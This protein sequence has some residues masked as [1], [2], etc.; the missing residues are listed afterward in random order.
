MP[1]SSTLSLLFGA[2][3]VVLAFVP[4]GNLGLGLG[5]GLI[6]GASLSGFGVAAQKRLARTRAAYVLPALATS[7]MLK[8]AA[9]FVATFVFLRFPQTAERFDPLTTLLA[10]AFAAMAVLLTGTVEVS[11]LLRQSG[12]DHPV[13][14]RPTVA[15]GA[16]LQG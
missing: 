4:G 6:L 15:Q 14:D 2:L 7:F 3:G 12:P 8:L 16:G 11:R 9:L 10:F 5:A 13:V 1:L